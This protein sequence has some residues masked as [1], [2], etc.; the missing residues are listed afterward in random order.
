ML[1]YMLLI[2]VHAALDTSVLDARLLTQPQPDYP[3][4]GSP[5]DACALR[6]GCTF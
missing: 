2:I 6:A 5:G 3:A 1:R 4:R